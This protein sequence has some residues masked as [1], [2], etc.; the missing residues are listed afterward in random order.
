LAVGSQPGRNAALDA[1]SVRAEIEREHQHGEEF[2]DCGKK[3]CKESNESAG[4]IGDDGSD[5]GGIELHRRNQLLRIQVEVE[6]GIQPIGD[7]DDDRR[8]S[9][10]CC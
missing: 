3:R 4:Q 2:E 6:A 9:L 5:A 7:G 8:S 10:D 1:M